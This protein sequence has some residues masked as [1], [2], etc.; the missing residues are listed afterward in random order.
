MQSE[1]IVGRKRVR[2]LTAQDCE[3]HLRQVDNQV[4]GEP[5]DERAETRE[6]LRV[7]KVRFC[8]WL[9]VEQGS[10]D[11][12]RDRPAVDTCEDTPPVK[13]SR[14]GQAQCCY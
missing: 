7:W 5:W 3:D 6:L 13:P 14:S 11:L 4:W 10:F 2:G 1:E 9:R 12:N 8:R